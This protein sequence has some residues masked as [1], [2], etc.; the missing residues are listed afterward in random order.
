[1]GHC[2]SFLNICFATQPLEYS[3]KISIYNF[4]ISLLILLSDES[5]MPK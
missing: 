3:T 5:A 1:M 2:M 4:V